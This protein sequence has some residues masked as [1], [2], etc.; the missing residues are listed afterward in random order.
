MYRHLLRNWK[1]DGTSSLNCRGRLWKCQHAAREQR[2]LGHY[3]MY[4]STILSLRRRDP[5]NRP[6]GF[7]CLAKLSRHSRV[8]L[9][10]RGPLVN[11]DYYL[12]RYTALPKARL[13]LSISPSGI[14][15]KRPHLCRTC[16]KHSQLAHGEGKIPTLTHLL[17]RSHPAQWDSGHLHLVPKEAALGRRPFCSFSPLADTGKSKA[18]SLADAISHQPSRPSL[19][20]PTESTLMAGVMTWPVLFVSCMATV[21]SPSLLAH[22]ACL[23]RASDLSFSHSSYGLNAILS[24]LCRRIQ[25]S[26]PSNVVGIDVLQENSPPV[27]GRER[28]PGSC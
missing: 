19:P 24:S 10:S 22:V 25:R 6:S 14:T 4:A 12:G 20:S 9:L 28:C 13:S 7:Q 1:L 16:F 8:V 18:S 5:H 2:I 27:G 11:G 23:G 15:G 3:R 21:L 26:T 17:T